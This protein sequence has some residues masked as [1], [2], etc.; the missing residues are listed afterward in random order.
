LKL[1]VI[2]IRRVIKKY[3]PKKGMEAIKMANIVKGKNSVKVGQVS[4]NKEPLKEVEE[5]KV[6]EKKS[7]R[8]SS[9]SSTVV[10]ERPA[11]K[12]KL[13]GA[14]KSANDPF[15]YLQH[16]GELELVTSEGFNEN[17]GIKEIKVFDPSDKQWEMGVLANCTIVMEYVTIKGVQ[18]RETTRDDSGAI[19]IQTQSRSWDGNDGKKQYMNDVEL[20]RPLQAQV[21]SFVEEML[22]EAE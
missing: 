2:T 13:G 19:Y 1:L 3:K 11:T 16:E 17:L 6:E 22:E 15:W 18:V 9:A 8:S 10:N 4:E 14:R 12:R 7:R 20:S 5:N 21:L